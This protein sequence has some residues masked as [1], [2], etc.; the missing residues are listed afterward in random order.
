V[1]GAKPLAQN[2]YKIALVKGIVTQAL[3]TIKKKTG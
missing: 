1:A 3:D 2:G